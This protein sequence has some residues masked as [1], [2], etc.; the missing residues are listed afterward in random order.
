MESAAP[1]D[2]V[3]GRPPTRPPSRR[4]RRRRRIAV[5]TVVAAIS[6][7]LL[8]FGII[9]LCGSVPN[10]VGW[11]EPVLVELRRS[12]FTVPVAGF[13]VVPAIVAVALGLPGLVASMAAITRMERPR[14]RPPR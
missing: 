3:P 11:G 1:P 6:A 7:E 14:R 8:L 5:L 10:F 4:R 2:P 9:A 12:Q 13:V